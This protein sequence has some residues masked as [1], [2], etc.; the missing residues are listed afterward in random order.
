MLP[1][2]HSDGPIV[3]A[4][5]IRCNDVRAILRGVAGWRRTFSGAT[6]LVWARRRMLGVTPPTALH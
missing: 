6:C 2:D 1:S 3:C 5:S 4:E